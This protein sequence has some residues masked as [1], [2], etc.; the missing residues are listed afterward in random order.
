MKKNLNL[1]LN[2]KTD[3]IGRALKKRKLLQALSKHLRIFIQARIAQLVEY[4]LGTGE[5]L[6]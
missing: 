5:V 3:L 1:K 6:G 2:L 4:Q